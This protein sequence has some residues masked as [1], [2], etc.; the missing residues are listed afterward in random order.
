MKFV[1]CDTSRL[2][3]L[4]NELQLAIFCE[5][6]DMESV[7]CLTRA[8]PRS[9]AIFR[10]YKEKIT[11][12]V[13]VN[14]ACRIVETANVQHGVDCFD[15]AKLGILTMCYQ[16][17]SLNF[18]SPW[19]SDY[20]ANEKM[21]YGAKKV[22]FQNIISGLNNI[23][24]P[25][26]SFAQMLHSDTQAKA[27]NTFRSMWSRVS[28]NKEADSLR[29]TPIELKFLLIARIVFGHRCDPLDPWT[30]NWLLN[31]LR[32]KQPRGNPIAIKSARKILELLYFCALASIRDYL[33]AY[34]R[35]ITT[36]ARDVA[37]ALI[38]LGSILS[39]MK[40]ANHKLGL[41]MNLCF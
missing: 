6:S 5:M 15:L 41:S 36:V 32:D 38:M 40:K 23:L 30:R 33:G 13:H 26:N 39:I 29:V 21:P 28:N 34:R 37:D 8:Y 19:M 18:S 14:A 10:L 1:I 31:L 35:D 12:V 3:R 7:M 22:K 4:P 9:K 16:N 2:T 27:W 24:T 20:F 11:N 25:W 17:R